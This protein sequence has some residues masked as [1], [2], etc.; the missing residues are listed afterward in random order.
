[1]RR[2]FTEQELLGRRSRPI[3]IAV[4]LLSFSGL[5]L[6]QTASRSATPVKTPSPDSSTPG[7]GIGAASG[8]GIGAANGTGVGAANG[9]GIGNSAVTNTGQH[10]R[11]IINWQTSDPS[12]AMENG[13]AARPTNGTRT[14]KAVGSGAG[15]PTPS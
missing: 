7:S 8:T 11:T 14:S 10:H 1:M 13:G 15:T 9:T 12:T 4:L 5:A 6:S 3:V 2:S